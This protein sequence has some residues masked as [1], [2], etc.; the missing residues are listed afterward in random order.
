MQSQALA[1]SPALDGRT[2]VG[3]DGVELRAQLAHDDRDRSGNEAAIMPYSTAVAPCSSRM[4]FRM[5]FFMISLLFALA[6][7]CVDLD[8]LSA[9]QP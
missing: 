3:E 7:G 5:A 4:N 2:D 1:S 8:Q 6:R 9:L